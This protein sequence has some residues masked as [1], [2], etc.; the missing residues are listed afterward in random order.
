MRDLFSP[1]IIGICCLGFPSFTRG[2]NVQT[3][4]L[5]DGK[6]LVTM[7]GPTNYLLAANQ[8]ITIKGISNI[9]G[10]QAFYYNSVNTNYNVVFMNNATIGSIFSGLTNFSVNGYGSAASF[11]VETPSTNSFSY[12]PANAVVIPSDANGPVQIIMESSSDLVNWV[13][14]L[15]G[16][17]GSQYS[18]RFFRVRA[19]VK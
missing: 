16:T 18:N 15:P 10:V 8:I 14:S 2:Q 9:T 1:L 11:T 7:I 6:T 12:I 3:F 17:Y 5:S 4:P 19:V 13:S